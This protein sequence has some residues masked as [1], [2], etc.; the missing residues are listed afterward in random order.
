MAAD[1]DLPEV[2]LEGLSPAMRAAAAR[3]G[4]KELMPVQARAI[5]YLLAGRDAMVQSR[6]GSGKTGAFLLPILERVDRPRA[7]CQA[8]VLVPTRELASQVGREAEILAGPGDLRTVAVYGGVGYG[9]QLEAFRA[10]AH[11][12]VGTPGRILDHLLRGSLSLRDLAILV[13][14]EA[15]RMLSMG[16]YPDMKEVQ[17]YLP[18]RRVTSFMFS[19]TFPS[20]VLHLAREFLHEPT[21]LSLSRDHV[22]VLDTVHVF[23]GVP[24]MERDRCLVRILEVENPASAIVFCNTR[25]SVRF[26]NEVL[27]RFGLDAAE[28]SADLAQ[29]ERERVMGR[30]REGSLRILVATDVAARGIDIP[31][32]SHVVLYEPPEDPEAYVHRAGRTGRAGASGRAITLVAG[33]EEIGLKNIAKRFGIDFKERPV[34]TDADVES[35]VSQ[36]MTAMLEARLRGRGQVERERLRRYLPLARSLAQ[37]EDEAELL[38][39]LLDEASREGVPAPSAPPRKAKRERR[40]RRR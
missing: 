35:I 14:D 20:H 12:V 25:Q 8:L 13:F 22:H 23:Y 3:A 33:V 10:G 28:L 29:A 36:R 38:A 5:P 1:S 11:V 19:A 34:P 37:I 31:D 24:A 15:D 21:T 27:Q 18:D 26:V 9:P 4:W 30:L 7:R 17:R 40:R 32:L 6:T 2:R 16:F 39:M